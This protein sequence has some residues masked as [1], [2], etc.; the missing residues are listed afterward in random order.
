MRAEFMQLAECISEIFP[1][2]LKETYYVPF[3][4]GHLPKGKLYDAYNNNR[5]R[6]RDA[7]VIRRRA[8]WETE[9]KT[10]KLCGGLLLQPFFLPNRRTCSC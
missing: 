10:C 3:R 5:T 4:N 9:Q 7:G 6:L 2:E 1:T 8:K